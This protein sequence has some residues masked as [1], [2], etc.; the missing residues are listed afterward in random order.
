MKRSV[1]MIVLLCFCATEGG[2][3]FAL[4]GG[5]SGT[6][7]EIFKIKG[8]GSQRSTY[9]LSLFSMTSNG[10]WI[11]RTTNATLSGNYIAIKSDRRFN[12]SLDAE[13]LSSLV[14]A[15]ESRVVNVCKS[16]PGSM[17][18]S[19]PT[20]TQFSA[21]T[22]KNHTTVGLSFVLTGTGTNG[23]VSHNLK[24]KFAAK[25][26]FDDGNGSGVG[27][28]GGD[29]TITIPTESSYT[30]TSCDTAHLSGNAF[31]SNSYSRCCSGDAKDTGV[32]VT[33]VNLITGA[34]GAADQYVRTCYGLFNYPYLCGHSWSADIPLILGDNIIKVTAVDPGG[35]GGTD[36]ITVY[37]PEYSYTVSGLLSTPEGT[38][39]GYDQSGIE[40]E[41]LSN[42]NLTTR[43]ASTGTVGDYEFTCIPNGSYTL[44]PVS[45]SF[46]YVFEPE[47]RTFTVADQDMTGID[48][49][50]DGYLVTGKITDASS[51][52]PVNSFVR[53]DIKSETAEWYW[54][55]QQGGTYS[56]VV[57]NGAYTI[58][59]TSTELYCPGGCTFTP[60]NR[61]VE[62]TDS[63]QPDI[64]FVYHH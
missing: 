32:T 3:A 49:K 57:P 63:S 42:E 43:P 48:F 23:I 7:T 1:L 53:M 40:V 60:E 14:A 46:T 10:T 62:I 58:T 64:D 5:G 17:S 35:T 54:Y 38:G 27:P 11:A 26:A 8:C 44:V 21:K 55:V 16:A 9:V 2:T 24:Y 6:Y 29:I 41:L 33:W 45:S 39:V 51:G 52:T 47:Y 20:I 25:L 22:N 13:S 30:S 37:K 15:L 28:S 56:F 61:T 50:A 59:P 31:I 34:T 19:N 18:I 12:L 36:T 4:D